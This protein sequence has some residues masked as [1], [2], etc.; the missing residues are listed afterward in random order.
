MSVV[1][2]NGEAWNAAPPYIDWDA[3]LLQLLDSRDEPRRPVSRECALEALATAI[4]HARRS[5]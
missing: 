2:A 4:L 1:D 3:V 5:P